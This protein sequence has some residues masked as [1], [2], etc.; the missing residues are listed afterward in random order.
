MKTPEKN[1]QPSLA[2]KED[3]FYH[4]DE[5]NFDLIFDLSFP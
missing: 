5:I 3:S 2:I 4:I 1:P